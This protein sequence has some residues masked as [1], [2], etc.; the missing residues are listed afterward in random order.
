MRSALAVYLPVQLVLLA[1]A[2][3]TAPPVRGLLSVLVVVVGTAT[4]TVSVARR[5]P[6]PWLAWWLVVPVPGR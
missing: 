4:F 3:A 2:I 5:R 6:Q 1:G